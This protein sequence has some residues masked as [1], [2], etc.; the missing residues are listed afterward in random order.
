MQ[1]ENTSLPSLTNDGQ[2]SSKGFHAPLGNRK[3][4]PGSADVRSYGLRT[5]I[6]RFENLGQLRIV[7]AHAPVRNVDLNVEAVPRTLRALGRNAD[8]ALSR[9]VFDSV[10]NQIFQAL[11]KAGK[12][13]HHTRQPGLNS[14]LD[15]E[16]RLMQQSTTI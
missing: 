10:G 1:A 6:E 8:P 9:A 5:P 3:A 14:L 7:D 15:G 13:R 11:G 16:A 2:R 4:Q 12:I